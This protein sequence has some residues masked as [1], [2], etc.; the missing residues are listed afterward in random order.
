[1][2]QGPL[3]LND[4]HTYVFCQAIC[5]LLDPPTKYLMCAGPHQNQENREKITD[6]LHV[7]EYGATA[8]GVSKMDNLI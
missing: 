5:A 6:F 1:M 3:I 7:S 4:Y 8:V 2:C